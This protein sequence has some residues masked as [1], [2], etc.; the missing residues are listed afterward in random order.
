MELE[1][2]KKAGIHSFEVFKQAW[3]LGARKF[4]PLVIA[5]FLTLP[6]PLF[7]G[8][9][10]FLLGLMAD[11][12]MGAHG[13]GWATVLASAVLLIMIGWCWAGWNYVCLK[14]ARGISPRFSDLFRPVSQCSS[15]FLA[16]MVTS[17][18]IGLGMMCFVLPG[19]YLFLKFQFTPFYIVDR[20]MGPLEAMK[21]SWRDTD[22]LFVPLALMDLMFWSLHFIS[23]AIFIGPFLCFMA[24]QV[25]NAIAFNKWLAD[26][27]VSTITHDLYKEITA[28]KPPQASSAVE[29]GAPDVVLDLPKQK[30]NEKL[31]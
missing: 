1:V 17:V 30:E 13:P 20:D 31:Q 16:L 9:V 14:I 22:Q 12:L 21:Q 15:G 29:E 10:L 4:I 7:I 25:A 3:L 24:H 5:W 6:L 19:A 26:E 8:A 23:G 2:V 18:A 27:E 28:S 11:R